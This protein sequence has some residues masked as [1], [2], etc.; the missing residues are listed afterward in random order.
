MATHASILAWKIP[1]KE[2]PG[3]HGQRSLVGYSLLGCKELDMTEQL[4]HTHTHTH[5]HTGDSL[6]FISQ[7]F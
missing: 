5:T 7:S 2:E 3:G 4:T 1:W 6:R